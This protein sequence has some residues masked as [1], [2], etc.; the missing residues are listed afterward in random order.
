MNFKIDI[1]DGFAIVEVQSPRLDSQSASKLKSE[2]VLLSGESIK[3][4]IIDLSACDYCDTAGI[5]AILVANRLCRDGVL[6]LAG[7]QPSVENLVSVSRF[8]P[9][10]DIVNDSAE[11]INLMQSKISNN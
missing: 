3:N 4:M 5:S 10:I 11:G 6:I 8:D 7:L 1:K 9:V 2:L